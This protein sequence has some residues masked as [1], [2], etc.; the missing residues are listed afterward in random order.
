MNE[1][2]SVIKK[3]ILQ[4]LQEERESPGK[5]CKK[6]GLS[7]LSFGLPIAGLLWIFF[8]GQFNAFWFVASIVW[9]SIGVAAAFSYWKPQPRLIVPGFWTPWLY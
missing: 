9:L 2:V 6:I 8:K 4:A 3:S 5:R 7:I 1:T